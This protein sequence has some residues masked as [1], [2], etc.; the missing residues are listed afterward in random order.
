M[1]A[2]IEDVCVLSVQTAR[3]APVNKNHFM[4]VFIGCGRIV[5]QTQMQV[6][7]NTRTHTRTKW[8]TQINHTYEKIYYLVLEHFWAAGD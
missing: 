6:H 3:L 2:G 7:T 4:F 8:R 5:I 1:E